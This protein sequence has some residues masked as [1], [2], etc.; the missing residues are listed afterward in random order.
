MFF[1]LYLGLISHLTI[2]SQQNTALFTSFVVVE[3]GFKPPVIVC[4]SA[5]GMEN[6]HIPDTA[7]TASSRYNQWWGPERARL[8]MQKEGI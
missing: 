2:E 7:I 6:G 1:F 4:A 5:L 8:N 3:I